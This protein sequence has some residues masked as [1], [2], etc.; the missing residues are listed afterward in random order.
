MIHIT[1]G[2]GLIAYTEKDDVNYP[3]ST[4]RGSIGMAI[5]CAEEEVAGKLKEL[6]EEIKKTCLSFQA[7]RNVTVE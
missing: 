7:T 6:L 1:V 4:D 5:D 2:T 3:V